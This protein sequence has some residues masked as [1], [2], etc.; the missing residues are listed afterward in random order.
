MNPKRTR[1]QTES[2]DARLVFLSR[3]V[4]S[5]GI[6]T[7]EAER[8][9][10]PGDLPWFVEGL[11]KRIRAISK[12]FNNYLE[13]HPEAL[14]R[15]DDSASEVVKQELAYA[16]KSLS[17]ITRIGKTVAETDTGKS[18]TAV[19]DRGNAAAFPAEAEELRKLREG[20]PKIERPSDS[21]G[22]RP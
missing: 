1:R 5:F 16:R 8:M 18:T 7:R 9:V 22:P 13:K 12:F 17:F 19:A 6:P 2:C 4:E 15:G 3:A 20:K 14:R 11:E 21:K 10:V